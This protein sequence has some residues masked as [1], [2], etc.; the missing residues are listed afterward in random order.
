MPSIHGWKSIEKAREAGGFA[1]KHGALPLWDLSK[2]ELVEIA[3]R[4]GAQ[5]AGE[6]DT[7]EAGIV[8]AMQEHEALRLNGIV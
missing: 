3:I 1:G 8:V 6:C 5:V 7:A 4:L 2:R